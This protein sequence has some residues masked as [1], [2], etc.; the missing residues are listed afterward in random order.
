MQE[1][2]D[3]GGLS[4]PVAPGAP[5]LKGKVALVSGA[6]RGI[7]QATAVRM[8][9]EGAAVVL[10]D[11]NGAEETAQQVRAA[12]G[13][14][15]GVPGS[16][17]DGETWQ[18]ATAAALESFGRIDC[19]ANV[20][21]VLLPLRNLPDN[22]I[23]I[24]P[25]DFDWLIDVNLRGPLLG[26]QAVLPTMLDRS[27][28]SIVNVSSGAANVGIA[29]HA[30]YAAT[31]G[32]VQSLTRQVAAEYGPRGVRANVIAPGAVKTPMSA[33]T[34]AEIQAAIDAATPLRR[35]GTPEDIASLIA[36]LA[37]DESS[38]I[39]GAILAIDGGRTACI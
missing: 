13:Q 3:T 33:S 20:A 7:G 10:I 25:E 9:Q 38:F 29:N 17:A 30:G 16:V 21:G 32:G 6:G 12:D 14:A 1:G 39:T 8:A 23:D 28:G 34:P 18:A 15:I 4:W 11:V 36:F 22:A 31:K 35:Q 27:A 24:T 2:T 26:M 37:S 19:L 5:R